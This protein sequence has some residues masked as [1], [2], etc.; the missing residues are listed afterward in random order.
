[1][2]D[3]NMVPDWQEQL[4]ARVDTFMEDRLGPD[5]VKDMKRFAPV[6][7]DGSNGRPAGYL[8]DSIESTVV[9]HELHIVAFADYAA[10][11]ENGHR[12]VNQH[13]PTGHWVPAQPFMR[14]A[15]YVKRKYKK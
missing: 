8:R 15:L 3:L 9:D 13:G 6:S 1:M 10:A 11:V 5:I 12:V 2:A 14:P 4:A 7:A